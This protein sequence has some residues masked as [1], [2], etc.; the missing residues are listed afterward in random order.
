MPMLLRGSA[1]VARQVHTLVVAGSNPAPATESLLYV[2]AKTYNKQSQHA[3]CWLTG[4]VAEWS[5]APVC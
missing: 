3:Q 5:N 1:V 2:R 4:E